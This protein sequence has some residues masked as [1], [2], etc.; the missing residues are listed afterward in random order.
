LVAEPTTLT[1]NIG[2]LAGGVNISKLAEKY[3]VED[4]TIHSTGADYKTAGSMMKPPTTQDTAYLQG[5]IDSMA[6]Q[7]HDVVKKGRQ[8][9]L[10]GPLATIFNAQAY[11]AKAALD[12][13]LVDEIG[14]VDDACKA[15]ASKAGLTNPTIQT[16]EEPTFFESLLTGKSDLPVPQGAA[17]LRINGTAVEVPRLHQLL[18]PRP[19]YL[20]R[21]E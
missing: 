15:A 10:K 5:L 18:D 3:G 9:R 8:G 17:D 19:M 12:L 21:P 20:Y 6:D 2:V 4:E 16:Y 1:A 7:F 13:G 14:Y 11:T